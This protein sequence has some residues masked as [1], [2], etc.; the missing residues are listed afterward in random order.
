MVSYTYKGTPVAPA[1][2][3]PPLLNRNSVHFFNVASLCNFSLSMRMLYMPTRSL[4]PINTRN[5]GW[6]DESSWLG[7]GCMGDGWIGKVKD[8]LVRFD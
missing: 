1:Q 4:K 6:N 3:C 8:R 5:P 7:D 2:Y